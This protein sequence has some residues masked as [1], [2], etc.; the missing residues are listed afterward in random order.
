MKYKVKKVVIILSLAF[1]TLGFVLYMEGIRINTSNSIPVGLY[2]MIKRPLTKGDYVIFCPPQKP[3]FH[4]ALARSYINPGFCPGGYGYMMKKVLATKGDTVSITS[5]GVVV[6][7]E[8]LPFSLPISRDSI[9]RTLPH[10][11]MIRY[12]LND[13]ELLL[14]TDQSTL[15]FDARYFGLLPKSQIKAVIVPI[16]TWPSRSDLSNVEGN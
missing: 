13:T 15:S 3:L 8:R 10:L 1:I 6:N 7:G 16:L 9:G 12:T 4:K 14:M 11:N 2:W 5:E